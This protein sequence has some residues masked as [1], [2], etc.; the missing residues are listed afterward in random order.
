MSEVNKFSMEM[1][2]IGTEVDGEGN[3][4]P[5]FTVQFTTPDGTFR[6][7]WKHLKE[8]VRNWVE[9]ERMEVP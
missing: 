3:I 2:C 6:Y 8:S 5:I 7:P 1:L 9:I 4:E